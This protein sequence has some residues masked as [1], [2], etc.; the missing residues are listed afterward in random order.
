[1]LLMYIYIDDRFTIQ[2]LSLKVGDWNTFLAK[3]Y[4]R[5]LTFTFQNSASRCGVSFL[6]IWVVSLPPLCT[7][8]F[9]KKSHACTYIPWRAKVPRVPGLA[10]SA[11]VTCRFLFMNDF[12]FFALIV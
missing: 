4:P 9:W 1:M 11:S 6:D 12:T 3:V 5:H 8:V 10:V 2:R 7:S